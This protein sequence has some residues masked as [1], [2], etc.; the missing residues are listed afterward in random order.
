[1][2]MPERLGR[3]ETIHPG[4]LRN[5]PVKPRDAAT[6]ILL[7]RTGGRPR[8]LLGKRSSKHVFMPD[9]YVFPGGRR[10][11]LDH[12]LPF[13]SDLHPDVLSRLMAE[14]SRNASQRG[15]RALALAAVRE[16]EEETGLLLGEQVAGRLHAQLGTLRYIA[17]AITPPGSV[18]RF[19]TRFFSTFADEA[20]LA[21]D[22]IADSHELLDLGWHDLQE[23]D[24]LNVPWITR[25][26]LT[27]LANLLRDDPA[28]PFGTSV[29]FYYCRRGQFLRSS[30]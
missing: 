12:V 17:R 15:A 25:S 23:L 24:G 28:L 20:G 5:P 1:M 10:D 4:E 8:V 22:R 14:K 19:D 6:L 29:P 21:L 13:A 9:T 26:V 2:S 3:V 16:L 11:R 27:D 7:D 18:R 30:L